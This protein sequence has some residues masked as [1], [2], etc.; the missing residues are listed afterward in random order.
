MI[1]SQKR[2]GPQ[3]IGEHSI[4]RIGVLFGT[5]NWKSCGLILDEL[6]SC[7]LG[8]QQQQ[9][10]L[11]ITSPPLSLIRTEEE[12]MAEQEKVVVIDE[13]VSERIAIG[14]LYGK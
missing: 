6:V 13:D 14:Q 11:S 4:P 9:Q 2:G 3:K 7:G 5:H 8:K 1:K 12:G 10:P